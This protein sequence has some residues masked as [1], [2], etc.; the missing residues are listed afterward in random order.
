METENRTPRRE[1]SR[2]K[3]SKKETSQIVHYT[4]PKPFF[5]KRLVMQLLTVAAVVLAIAIGTSVFFKVDTVVVSG[6][7][8]YSPETVAQASGVQVGDSLLFFGRGATARR[9]KTALPYVGN[10]RFEVSLPGTVNIIIEEKALSYSVCA[11]DG[12]WW[13]ITS[14]GMVV[15]KVTDSTQVGATITGVLL[16]SPSVGRM[17]EAE[18]SSQADTGTATAAER[19]QAAVSILS[20]MEYWEL[21]SDVT[22]V[23][24]SDLFDLRLYCD[25]RYR[26]ELGAVTDMQ[27]KIGAVKAVLSDSQKPDSG[28]LELE[29]ADGKWQILY[30]AWP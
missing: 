29:Y 3:R 8:K 7:E 19:L 28:V 24:V 1:N 14:D 9:I 16:N 20:Q 23:D 4:Q 11:S 5:R 13:K 22:Q 26:I 15:E 17:A 21:F 12:S 25:S 6:A 10:V 2:R 30:Y 18:Q 27:E